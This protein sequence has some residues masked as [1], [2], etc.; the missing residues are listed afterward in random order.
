MVP[1]SSVRPRQHT[2]PT[3]TTPSRLPLGIPAAPSLL[4]RTT[5]PPCARSHADAGPDRGDP[6]PVPPKPAAHLGA[7]TPL[8]PHAWGRVRVR[9]VGRESCNLSAH[10]NPG[11]VGS[12]HRR[13]RE[14]RGR[15]SGA[16][17]ARPLPG[18]S[19]GGC[20]PQCWLISS[21]TK[22]RIS[23][24]CRAHGGAKGPRRN[25]GRCN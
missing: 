16:A 22:A 19:S 7:E 25:G 4:P 14:R 24:S 20:S 13:L 17:G 8:V 2:D 21:L 9:G 6:P 18:A 15:G 10:V 23:S 3:A 1:S 5:P 11:A 12:G